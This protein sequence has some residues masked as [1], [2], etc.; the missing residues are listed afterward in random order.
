VLSADVKA[1]VDAMRGHAFISYVREDAERI[2]RLEEALESA[3]IPVWRDTSDLAFGSEWRMEIRRAITEDALAFI[4]CFSSTSCARERS[5][6]RGELALAIEEYQQRSSERPWLIPVRLDDCRLPRVDLGGGKTLTSLHWLDLFGNECDRNCDRLIDQIRKL[7]PEPDASTGPTDPSADDPDGFSHEDES[8]DAAFT[9]G[10]MAPTGS[11]RASAIMFPID[12]MDV[13]LIASGGYPLW[14]HVEALRQRTGRIAVAYADLS[15]Q[16]GMIIAVDGP[17]DANWCTFA[18]WSSRSIESQISD[19]N[20]AL[21]ILAAGNRAL[22]LD[23]GTAI[24]ALIKHFPNRELAAELD[25][26]SRWAACWSTI[27]GRLRQFA[28]LDPSEPLTAQTPFDELRLGLEQ[29]FEALRVEDQAQRSQHV[30]AGNLL[31]GAYEQRRLDGYIGAA[32]S[33]SP[34]AAMRNLMH[35]H[36]DDVGGIR[37][38]ANTAVAM[39]STKNM[40]I[41]F[42]GGE[43]IRVG[44]PIPPPVDPGDRWTGLATLADV[45]LPILQ[46]LMTRYDLS[47]GRVPG[48]G[49]RNWTSFDQRM[50]TMG[51]LFRLRQRQRSLF[52]LPFSEVKTAALMAGTPT[53]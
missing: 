21:R 42:P 49:A 12:T 33:G 40:I 26:E 44:R 39:A 14:E 47:S 15:R 52:E 5:V 9:V 22:F 17:L 4:A 13:R 8:S 28:T 7:L 46:G 3:G 30:L 23:V 41:Q 34:D 31:V 19:D 51:D 2:D 43:T 24:A 18:T 32:L 6:Q 50:R 53:S 25:G 38:W 45:T 16:L 1:S 11:T 48:G 37:R 10:S 20:P 36:T 35:D 27:E 29:Y